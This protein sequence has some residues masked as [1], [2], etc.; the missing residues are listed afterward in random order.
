M[1]VIL[2]GKIGR[3][4]HERAKA[5]NPD[6]FSLYTRELGLIKA[7]TEAQVKKALNTFGIWHYRI[8]SS[9][10]VSKENIHPFPVAHGKAYLYHNGVLGDGLP[11]MSD[12]ACLAKTL[13]DCS[14]STVVSVLK[15]LETGQRFLLVDSQDP[16]NFRL[17]GDWKVHAGVIM[18]HKNCVSPRTVYYSKADRA[19]WSLPSITTYRDYYE[20]DA[21]D[22]E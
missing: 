17:Y 16:T 11:T 19:G 12:T 10:G 13:Y 8:A 20:E 9:G 22:E 14:M 18:S 15:S 2:V 5:Q 7:P 1:C 21:N 3:Q 6:G 4:L